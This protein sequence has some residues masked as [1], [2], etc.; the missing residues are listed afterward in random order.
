V[1]LQIEQDLKWVGRARDIGV[2][3]HGVVFHPSPR[4]VVG[5]HLTVSGK[6]PSRGLE[7]AACDQ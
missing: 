4:V 3:G 5:R 6:N 1:S 7:A 2:L